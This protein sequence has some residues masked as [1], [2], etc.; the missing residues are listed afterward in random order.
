LSLRDPFVGLMAMLGTIMVL[1][2]VVYPPIG[3]ELLLRYYYNSAE[4]ERQHIRVVEIVGKRE[5]VFTNG[6]RKEYEEPA[7]L[8]LLGTCAALA[9]P[10]FL[11]ACWLRVRY[12]PGKAAGRTGCCPGR[13]PIIP[14]GQPSGH[15]RE[16]A[17]EVPRLSHVAGG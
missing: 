15:P 5:V 13:G 12:G 1:W 9:A 2:L 10:V 14:A 17:D 8:M 7:R 3:K 4:I 16:F 11:L 6:D